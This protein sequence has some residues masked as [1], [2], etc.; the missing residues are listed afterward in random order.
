[1]W[2]TRSRPRRRNERPALYQIDSKHAAIVAAQAADA[3]RAER[4]VILDVRATL[5]VTDFFVISSAGNPRQVKAV[6][7]NVEEHLRHAGRR[8][9]H[10]EGVQD[11]R[12]V[13]LDYGDFVVHVFLDQARDYY[14][15][16]RLWADSPCI[17]WD[18]PK[19][20]RRN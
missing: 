8:P 2:Q 5:G 11:A 3:K 15:L 7:D 19:L 13:L 16:E 1:V 12:W 20:A 9:E 14:D 17:E 10:R 6:V 4:V 18:E